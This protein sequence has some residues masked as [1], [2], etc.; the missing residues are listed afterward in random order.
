MGNCKNTH[1]YFEQSCHCLC[2]EPIMRAL[3]TIWCSLIHVSIWCWLWKL[4]LNMLLMFLM[5][6]MH[7]MLS[8]SSF[9]T[10]L[11]Q[12]LLRSQNLFYRPMIHS[13]C[14]ICLFLCLILGLGL[15]RLWKTMWV[16]GLVFV[17]LQNMILMQ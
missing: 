5:F 16:V 11:G 15:W 10:T 3:A 17:L 12:K 9:K 8:L 14:T 1:I 13:R 4:R 7:L 6:W 2:D